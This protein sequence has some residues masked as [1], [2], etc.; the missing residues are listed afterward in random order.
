MGRLIYQLLLSLATLVAAPILLLRRRSHYA[1]SIR[2]RLGL[3]KLPAEGGDPHLWIHAVSVGEVGVAATLA[4]HI[5][6]SLPLL[7][8]TVTPTGQETARS[9]FSD[10]VVTYLPFDLEIPVRRF[11]DHFQPRLLLLTEGDL[12]PTVLRYA[13]IRRVPV[14]VINGRISDRSFRR[15]RLVRPFLAAIFQPIDCFGVQTE[16]DRARLLDLGVPPDKVNI[17]GNL[18]FDSPE[19]PL[20]DDLAS[21]VNL[22]A[23]GRPMLIAGSTMPGE[24]EQVL[25]AFSAIGAGDRA[26]LVLAPRHP[27]RWQA[28][29]EL[30]EQGSLDWT[31]RSLI[32]ES[33]SASPDVVLLDTL[34]EL[35]GLYRLATAAF[36]GGTLSPTGGHNP[37][38]AAC[39]GVPVVVGPSME[40][41]Q[42][43]E[44][45]FDA[46]AAWERVE[47]AE[48]LAR[49]WANWLDRPE[50]ASEVGKRGSELVN[51][52]RGAL[53]RTLELIEPWLPKP[54]TA[55]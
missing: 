31:R 38:E 21:S 17:T 46:A 6:R 39:F 25:R 44:T 41:F 9:R 13:Q 42:E 7:V 45:V 3:A 35:A 11:F 30:L 49:C 16:A 8:T 19:P 10:A 51:R 55:A 15:M 29:A 28:V 20:A 23:A 32:G 4:P 47:N 37:L 12:W 18:K 14:V 26:L 40:N 22:M 54:R 1:S 48:Q 50:N 24:E 43:I 36:I 52:H 34:G 5:P 27:E 53:A 33:L 2:E